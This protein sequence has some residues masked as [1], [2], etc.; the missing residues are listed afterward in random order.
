MK[1]LR[2]RL[3]RLDL[4]GFRPTRECFSDPWRL[5]CSFTHSVIPTFTC[6]CSWLLLLL[7]AS[8]LVLTADRSSS[9]T[10]VMAMLRTHLYSIVLPWWQE[11]EVASIP[12]NRFWG[13]KELLYMY[14]LYPLIL[15][16]EQFT[17]CYRL[18]YSACS[19]RGVFTKKGIVLQKKQILL[20]N[21]NWYE[22]NFILLE[23]FMSVTVLKVDHR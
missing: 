9:L 2:D 20:Y 16:S 5:C 13:V 17:C 6:P 1:T 11:G 4:A 8:L 7:G 18:C 10:W 21:W 12:K 22:G 14:I 15:R 3:C 19:G 23:F